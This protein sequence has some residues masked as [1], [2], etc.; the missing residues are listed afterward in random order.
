MLQ[1][2]VRLSL[3]LGLRLLLRHVDVG[4]A[5]NTLTANCRDCA[6]IVEV[7]LRQLL[8]QS[9]SIQWVA[10]DN[11]V[12]VIAVGQV[13]RI[14]LEEHRQVETLAGYMHPE[15]SLERIW[16][17]PESACLHISLLHKSVGEAGRRNCWESHTNVLHI[18]DLFDVGDELRIRH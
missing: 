3:G 11:L 13:I 10:N 2:I 5:R 4:F 12:I 8:V 17:L 14:Q 18:I 16:R 15:Q 1:R 9:D 6:R 7:V